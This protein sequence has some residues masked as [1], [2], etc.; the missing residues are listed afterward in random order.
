MADAKAVLT[1]GSLDVLLA[2]L[3]VA[4]TVVLRVDTKADESVV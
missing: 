1:V 2:G 3:L 4:L